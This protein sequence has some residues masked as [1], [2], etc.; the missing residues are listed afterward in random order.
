MI[1]SNS[2]KE[3]VEFFLTKREYPVPKYEVLPRGE[4]DTET[5]VLEDGTK[6]PFLWWRHHSKINALRS[7]ASDQSLKAIHEYDL[8][9]PDRVCCMNVYSFASV[10]DSLRQHIYREID[11]AEYI[12]GS[13]TKKVTAFMNGNACNL[14]AVMESGA[15]ANLE[16]GATMA[17]GTEIQCQHKLITTHGMANDRAVD[18]MTVQPAVSVFSDSPRPYTYT[19]IESYAYGLSADDVDRAFCLLNFFNGNDK[20]ED[21]IESGKH[22]CAVVDAVYKSAELGE[23]CEVEEK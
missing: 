15:V 10:D 20:I 12:L 3:T 16:L 9:A 14:I 6:V 21:Y 4:N 17:S 7:Y 23:T 18:T 11:T 5:L 13:K 22:V 1:R 8:Q 2:I 19:D